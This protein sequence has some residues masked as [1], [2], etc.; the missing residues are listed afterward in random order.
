[1]RSGPLPLVTGV[2]RAYVLVV[3]EQRIRQARELSVGSMH[4]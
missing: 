2:P 1:M 3:V 4:G